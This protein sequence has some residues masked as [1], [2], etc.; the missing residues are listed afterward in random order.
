[1]AVKMKI[2]NLEVYGDSILVIN[3]LLTHYKVRKDDLIPYH[4]MATQ[5]LEKFDFVTLEHIPRKDNEMVNALANLA[6]TLTLALTKDE[7]VYLLVC[8]HWVVPLALGAS[9]EGVNVI[10]VFSID[11]DDLRQPLI[12]Y[13]EH[14]KLP[15]DSRHRSEVHRRAHHFIYYKEILY[16]HSF[17]GVFLRCLEE[18]DASKAMKEAHSCICRAH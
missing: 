11:V 9:Q 13:L 6:S 8:Y 15:D 12:D 17:E 10:S 14:G 7:A 3:Q 4:Q 18:D 16:C 2:S 5:L 1:M